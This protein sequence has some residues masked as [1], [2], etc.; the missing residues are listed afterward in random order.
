[1]AGQPSMSRP[2]PDR[3]SASHCR[4]WEAP[5][6]GERRAYEA[7]RLGLSR[8]RVRRPTGACDRVLIGNSRVPAFSATVGEFGGRNFEA[9]PLPPMAK[10]G[11]LI[12]IWQNDRVVWQGREEEIPARFLQQDLDL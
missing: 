11:G 10:G 12:T 7:F 5:S 6:E 8:R 9:A 4:H 2:I 3:P 1:M